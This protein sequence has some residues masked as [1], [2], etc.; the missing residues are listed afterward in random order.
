M[1]YTKP[2]R[3]IFYYKKATNKKYYCKFSNLHIN[4]SQSII[5]RNNHR[6]CSIRKDVPRNFAK[7]TGKHLCQ[8]LFL[9]K[10]QVIRPTTLSK[11][12]LW[13]RCFPVNFEKFLR[14]PFFTEHLRATASE[15][16]DSSLKCCI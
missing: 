5:I 15:S 6:R 3:H 8:G 1:C 7:F 2:S 13:R 11:K 9:K 4:F 12:K 10:L 16:S 14:T